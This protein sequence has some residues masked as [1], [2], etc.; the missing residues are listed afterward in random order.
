MRHYETIFII[1]P[2]LNDDDTNQVIEKFTG[3]LKENGAEILKTDVW[4]RRRLAYAVKKFNKGF[5]VVCE[6]GAESAAVVEMERNFKIN[7]KIIRFLT[8]KKG[9][10]FDTE[11]LA[12]AE[13][14]AKARAEARA[15]ALAA[16]GD[17]DEDDIMGDDDYDQEEEEDRA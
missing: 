16:R 9:D 2:D 6:F 11:V 10:V 14:A 13:A 7:E 5:Y 8:V 3:I 12:R 4:G 15:A 1:N 17:D